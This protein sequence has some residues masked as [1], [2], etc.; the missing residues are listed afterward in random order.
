[1]K[2]QFLLFFFLL[3]SIVFTYAQYSYKWDKYSVSFQ[4]PVKLD[5]YETESEDVFGSDNDEYAVDIS[6]F[7]KNYY[8]QYIDKSSWKKAATDIAKAYGFINVKDGGS[9]PNII[10]GYYI[11]CESKS[12]VE[13]LPD[14]IVILV[15][16]LDENKNH[17][18][19][20]TIYCYNKSAEI[21]IK[22]AKTFS[23]Y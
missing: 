10:Q 11:I 20:A 4:S 1:M 16:A 5:L 21:G 17:Y 14:A 2:K 8:T 6:G 13:T 23:F 15:M 18:I 22:I 9:L 7:D 3:F 12:N 19:E